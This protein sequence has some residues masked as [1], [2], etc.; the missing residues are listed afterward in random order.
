MG[1]WRCYAITK[2]CLALRSVLS[3]QVVKDASWCIPTIAFAAAKMSSIV[4]SNSDAAK[5][6]HKKWVL[7]LCAWNNGLPHSGICAIVLCTMTDA[8]TIPDGI[9]GAS[10]V[11][12]WFLFIAML[13]TD[14]VWLDVVRT[15]WI[16]TL[17]A[18][19]MQMTTPITMFHGFPFA[20][21]MQADQFI[22]DDEW[23]FE[24]VSCW[25]CLEDVGCGCVFQKTSRNNDVCS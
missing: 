21:F 7:H 23:C 3:T 11:T 13:D 14:A 19:A 1:G 2:W 12:A 25:V 20:L 24:D 22:H 10:I 8:N 5:E 6:R 16:W 9:V 15:L 18:F 17:S 4:E